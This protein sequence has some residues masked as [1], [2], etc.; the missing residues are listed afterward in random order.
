M[1]K[2]SYIKSVKLPDID[3]GEVLRY[4]GAKEQN[5]ELSALL[6]FAIKETEGKILSNICYIELPIKID[7]NTCD[8][9]IFKLS[10]KALCRHLSGYKKA[11]LFGATLGAEI[12]RI[13]LKYSSLSPSK[14]L[15]ISALGSER[16]EALCDVFCNGKKRFSAGYGDLSLEAQKEIF[17]ALDCEKKI[18]LTLTD[19]LIMAPSKSVTAIFGVK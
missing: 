15:M 11:I 12:D 14:A 17:L 5:A 9:G 6:N 2:V 8:F 18:G 10:S 16:I 19:S 7:G 4:A 3:R 1:K 13:I